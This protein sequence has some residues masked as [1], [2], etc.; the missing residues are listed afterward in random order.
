MP[1]FFKINCVFFKEKYILCS[2]YVLNLSLVIRLYFFVRRTSSWISV[3]KEIKNYIHSKPGNPLT[4]PKR[5][6][7]Y[8][9]NSR[10]KMTSSIKSDESPAI[11]PADASETPPGINIYNAPL[12]CKKYKWDHGTFVGVNIQ[13]SG[14]KNHEYVSFLLAVYIGTRTRNKSQFQQ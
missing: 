14:R 11:K 12:E 3:T 8:L 6:S 5:F 4:I 2:N 7:I 13:V 9:I 1:R 10:E